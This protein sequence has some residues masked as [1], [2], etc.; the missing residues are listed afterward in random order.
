MPAKI[1]EMLIGFGYKKQTNISTANILAQIWRL[2]KINT[3]FTMPT[4]NTENDAA[5]LGKGHEFATQVF[6][7]SW[8]VK[9][10][11]EKYC[12]SDFAAWV[13]CFGLGHVV[14][15]GSGGNWIYTVKPLDPVVEGIE[16][17]YFSYL[18]Q[19]RPGGSAVVDHMSVG[20]AIE[21]WTLTINSG[22]GR[23][24]SKLV[25]S[26]IGSG[27]F[28]KPS[29]ISLPAATV[30]KLLPSASLALVI[31]GVDYVTNKNIV[32]LTATWKNNLHVD[33]GFY[34]GSGFQGAQKQVDTVTLIGTSGTAQITGAGGL[35]K[36]VSWATDLTTTA[37]NFVTANASAYSAVGIVLTSVGPALIFT[38]AVAGTGFVHAVI[39]NLTG[40][41]NGTVVWTTPNEVLGE[42]GAIR[43]RLECGDRDCGLQ[44]T[45]RYAYGSP[46]LNTLYTLGE[47][48]GILT[49]TYDA[50]NYLQL[51]YQRITFSVVE[52]GNTDGIVTVQ[53]TVQP[54]YHA[55][56]GIL[57]A[58]AACN[59][60]GIGQ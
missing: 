37:S 58:V 56:N 16:L 36:T 41:L 6:K 51:A 57:T 47:G 2:N 5:D 32:S 4:L 54:L 30:E 13:M 10:T 18:E 19:M 45:A 52:L 44:F 55:A 48:T 23:I 60:T 11:L 9:G 14:Q 28:V 31:N 33:S 46:E 20:C 42:S 8:D 17:P 34:P 3:N 53:V 26:V 38:A 35:T 1:Q 40:D 49:V 12:S 24:N 7:T 39:T 43:G 15:T 50:N 21:D 25:A 29:G 22:P 59:T 27:I